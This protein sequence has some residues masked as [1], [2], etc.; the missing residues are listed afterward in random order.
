MNGKRRGNDKW[1]GDAEKSN[2]ELTYVGI[3]SFVMMTEA[4]I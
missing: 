3:I 4:D 1:I 2:T